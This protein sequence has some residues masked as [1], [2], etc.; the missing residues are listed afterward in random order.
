M[1][2][3]SLPQKFRQNKWVRRA[4]YALAGV[5]VLWVLAWAAVPPLL[6]SQVE[7]VAT[8]KLGRHVTLGAVDFR[9]WTLELTL[10]DLVVAGSGGSPPQ[11]AIKR[12]YID[13]ELQSLLRLAPV[14]DAVT[15]EGVHAK[16]VHLG[17][18]SY[19]ID[20]IL[21]R[22]AASAQ[23]E[24]SGQARFA[25][26]NL[27]VVGG[28][29]DFTDQAVG[30]TQ[31]VRE[32]Q[33]AL[34]FL[35][36]LDSDRDIKVEP[37]LAFRLNGSP[38]DSAAAGTP[39]TQTR[40]T[41]ASIRLKAFDVRPFVGY[42]PSTVPVRLQSGVVEADLR[43][44]FEQS[45]KLAVKLSGTVQASGVKLADA[46]G[47]DLL[48]FDGL[49]VDLQDVRPLERDVRLSLVELTGPKLEVARDRAG[50]INLLALSVT[51]EA[52]VA[53]RPAGPGAVATP[54]KVL[55]D[56]A[57]IRGGAVAW[58]DATTSPGTE[59]A[60][61]DLGLDA[62]G[63]TFPVAQAVPFEGS[64]GLGGRQTAS[65]TFSGSAVP[66]AATASLTIRALPLDAAAPYLAAYLEPGLSGQMAGDVG[67]IWKA[68]RPD[69]KGP[70][71]QLT[72]SQLSL[73]KLALT[74][75][76]TV[77]A[78]V[79]KL[80]VA[81]AEI[82][83]VRQS[84][85]I[86][87]LVITQPRGAIERGVDR[88]WMF[89]RWLK[90]G[91]TPGASRE[92]GTASAPAPVPD[93]KTATPGWMLELAEG[94][95]TGGNV[96]FSD[97][98]GPRPVIFGVSAL[99]VQA[100]AFSLDGKTAGPVSV[101]AR[102][103]AGHA[104]AG[105]LDFKG[106]LAMQPLSV[107][108][109]VDA[110][111]LP[112]HAFEPYFGDALN[113]EL[114]RADASFKGRMRYAQSPAGPTLKLTGDTA[115]EEFR[116]NSVQLQG[117]GAARGLQ[118]AEELLAW[119]ALG[120]RGLDVSMAPGV[121]TQVS[122][123][124]TTLSDFFARIIINENGRINLQ[125]VVKASVPAGTSSTMAATATVAAGPAIAQPGNA[126]NAPVATS[127]PPNTSPPVI[128]FGPVNLLNGKVLFS[129]RFVKPN[130][131]ANLS[132][133]NGKLSAFTS[134]SPQGT[135]QLADLELRGR[136]EGTASLEVLGKL[137]PLAK[138]LALDIKGKVRDLELP[139]LSPYAI[140]YAGHGIERGKLSL[141][142]GYVVLPNGQLTASNRLMLNQLSFG[143]P[144][145]GAP[146]SLPVKLAVALL[147][148]RNGLIDI[149]LPISGSLNDPQF[150]LGPVIFKVIANL[151]VKAITAPFSLLAGAFG[152]G[153]D[154]LSMVSFAPGTSE[155]SPEARTG[156][157]RVAKALAERPALKMTVVGTA[158]LDVE[159][160]AVKRE[161]L[162]QL[163]RAEK[164]REA[165]VAGATATGTV[166]VSDAEA[167]ALLKEVYRRADIRKP[168]NVIGIA[169][170]LPQGEMED[171]LLVNVVV[172]DEVIRDLAVQRGVAVRDYL[173][174]QKL[175]LERLFL[176]AA[177]S[178]PPEAKWTP[179]AELN[180]AA[181]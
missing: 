99:Q 150:S 82:D 81:Q 172:T 155:L 51:P 146:N 157:D 41:D 83:L 102:V 132:E 24:P 40:K 22:L 109:Q 56:K 58:K 100:K 45:P 138:P 4:A 16:L 18:G 113:I 9:P 153:G 59:L 28:S 165:V 33:L 62:S 85:R 5:V 143:E 17:G 14:I 37:R 115:L 64:A 39:F 3:P 156:L 44:A 78:A 68:A 147:A 133:L 123:R 151:V 125:D 140:K 145:A 20:D 69:G 152:G 119:R 60:L 139:P 174:S 42:L 29:V 171:L 26:Y 129:D 55:L 15:I 6:K 114:L 142:V 154:E 136:A 67:V 73:D 176:G 92:A 112:L 36:N 7:K 19:D 12:L 10:R 168:R 46:Q 61:R 169:K 84:V 95:L 159:R 124:E 106:T 94:S 118:A 180:L 98:S 158:S 170:D 120:L 166:T 90:A 72:A 76:K 30:K 163:L 173:A 66:D 161:R 79:Q 144:V 11:L 134:V 117:T 141:D 179:R 110:V 137:N 13:A 128:S 87:K 160:D 126:A 21:G 80:D 111:D 148:D 121:A 57:V 167:P 75:G 86:G 52:T 97:R 70:E 105:K 74:Q 2:P 149:D 101:S 177:K 104:E 38:F 107:Q 88:R 49:K 116:A 1:T 71:L 130:Y 181:Q 23:P 108:G 65:F 43:L 175:P 103:G 31:Q 54:W 122:V 93:T 34:P 8:E 63:I 32:L 47:Q 89:E 27:S 135:P 50:R 53:S 131:S 162:R 127:A 25:L 164:R 77:L 35:S 91:G 48:A 178:V 96:Q